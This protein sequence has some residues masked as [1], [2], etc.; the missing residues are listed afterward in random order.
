MGACV[1]CQETIIHLHNDR[2]G[3][4]KVLARTEKTRATGLNSIGW[5]GVP[6]CHN[7]CPITQDY[8]PQFAFYTPGAGGRGGE[9]GGGG[10]VAGIGAVVD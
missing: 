4:A 3:P 5:P 2:P 10:R 9:G 6:A 7:R 1:T 8:I